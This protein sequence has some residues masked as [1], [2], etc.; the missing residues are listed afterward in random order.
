MT[1]NIKD[2][3]IVSSESTPVFEYDASTTRFSY[4]LDDLKSAVNQPRLLKT[5]VWKAFMGRYRRSLLGPFWITLSTL[6]TVTGL[7]LMYGRILGASLEDYFPYVTAGIIVFGFVSSVING[8]ATAFGTGAAMFNEMPIAKS[9]FAFRSVGT[10]TLSFL[11]KIPVVLGVLI[12]VGRFPE[13]KGLLLSLLGVLLMIWT[14][15]WVTLMVGTFGMRFKDTSHTITSIMSAIF[16]LTP[17][18]WMRGRLGYYEFIVDF[19]PLYHFLH[20]I[21]GPLLGDY[22]LG[23]SFVWAITSAVLVTVIGMVSFGYF[24]RRFSYWT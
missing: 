24:A 19:N 12:F 7:A 15:F 14:G 3:K 16:F 11:F 9:V 17:V 18:F 13:A 2:T 1:E 21:R 10:A 8:A 4:A 6:M 5:V 23:Y 22:D 20:L